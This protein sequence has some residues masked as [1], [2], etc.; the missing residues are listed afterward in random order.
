[1]NMPT[2]KPE[3][4]R[5]N[6]RVKGPKASHIQAVIGPQGLY[7][8]QN[9]DILNRAREINEQGFKKMD[10]LHIACAIHAGVHYFL[11]TDDGIIKKATSVTETIITDPIGFIKEVLP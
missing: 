11:T 8:N 9:E 4:T 7:E 6:V 1:M 3:E 10:S 2:Q 5:I